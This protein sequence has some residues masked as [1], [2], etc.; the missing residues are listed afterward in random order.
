MSSPLQQDRRHNKRSAT[1]VAVGNKGHSCLLLKNGWCKRIKVHPACDGF[2][3]MDREAL[4]ALVT[5]FVKT[6][7][8]TAERQVSQGNAVT[9]PFAVVK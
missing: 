8:S 3:L 4:R 1:A 2:P 7:S 5:I 9:M 6:V